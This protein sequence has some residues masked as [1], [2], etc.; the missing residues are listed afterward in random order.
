MQTG[1]GAPEKT[2]E[3]VETSFSIKRPAADF[4]ASGRPT[5]VGWDRWAVPN[6]SFTKKSA[7]AESFFTR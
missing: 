2:F 4:I 7:I 6:A 5:T 3:S 1:R